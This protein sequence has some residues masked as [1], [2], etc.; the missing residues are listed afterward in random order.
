MFIFVFYLCLSLSCLSTVADSKILI[1]HIDKNIKLIEIWS[2]IH[3]LNLRGKREI[4]DR[5]VFA[6]NGSL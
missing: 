1:F 5:K 3:V 4:K 2:L 6:E